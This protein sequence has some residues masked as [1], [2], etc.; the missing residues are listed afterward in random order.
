MLKK[1]IMLVVSASSAFALHYAEVN[2]NNVDVNAKV[3]MDMGQFNQVI[4]P[5]TTFWGLEYTNGSPSH[6]N[7]YDKNGGMGDVFF[8]MMRPLGNL[9]DLRV[10]LGMK[11]VFTQ[12]NKSNFLAL[13]FGLEVEYRLPFDLPV[14][15]YLGANGYASPE[16]LSFESAKNYF[17]YNANF[18]IEVIE[19]ARLSVSYKAQHTNFID[20]DALYNRAVY[21]GVKFGF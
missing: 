14:N 15:F 7:G 1:M 9:E 3:S 5:D 8:L 6:S 20:F 11:L 21:F 17:S 18:D 2:I 12:L 19:R 10:G 13:P 4:E 16:V